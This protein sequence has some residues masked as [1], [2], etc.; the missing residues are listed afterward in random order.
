MEDI[1]FISFSYIFLFLYTYFFLYL[2]HCALDNRAPVQQQGKETGESESLLGQ[3]GNHKSTVP[4]RECLHSHDH[5]GT[6]SY[7]GATNLGG[8][9]H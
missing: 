8:G 6:M 5:K 7:K 1:F 4:V 3:T 2:G 9:W